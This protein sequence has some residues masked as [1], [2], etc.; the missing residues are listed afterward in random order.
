MLNLISLKR[1]PKMSEDF[2]VVELFL[3]FS[4]KFLWVL[5]YC[6]LN[7]KKLWVIYYRHPVAILLTK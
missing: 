3:D 2:C 5:L 1:L 6:I 7:F 4:K